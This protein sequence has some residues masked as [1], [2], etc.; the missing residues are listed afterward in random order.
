MGETVG[1]RFY[2]Q[3]KQDV[4][5]NWRLDALRNVISGTCLSDTE[6]LIFPHL[7]LDV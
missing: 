5:W 7:Y 6:A 2:P 1:V 4:M 3:G